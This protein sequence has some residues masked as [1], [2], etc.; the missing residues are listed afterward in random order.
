MNQV[1]FL[2][3]DNI[4]DIHDRLIQTFGGSFGLRDQNLLES[5]LYQPQ[6]KI[7]GQYMHGNLYF[8]AAVYA[9]HIIKNHPFIDGNKRT[10]IFSAITFLEFN[11]LS[12]DLG[13]QQ[14]YQLAID[15]A[16][17]KLSKKEIAELLKKNVFEY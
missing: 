17:S 1:N 16:E 6:V 7:S 14:L 9:Y 15:I 13:H 10:G 2:T 3:L 5:A 11:D 12:I 8:M 4:L